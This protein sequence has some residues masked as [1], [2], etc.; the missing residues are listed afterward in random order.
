MENKQ[1]EYST[2]KSLIKRDLLDLCLIFPFTCEFTD[3]DTAIISYESKLNRLRM[4][5]I[6]LLPG[7][8]SNDFKDTNSLVL[9][10][11]TKLWLPGDVDD[12]VK[13]STIFDKEPTIYNII[14]DNDLEYILPKK[15][16][17]KYS[18]LK[19]ELF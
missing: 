11:M 3:W 18:Y 15:I 7:D 16:I 8:E 10:L 5:R 12:N 1:Y 19:N 6:D 4:K 9:Y 17:D 13:W 2:Y 14:I